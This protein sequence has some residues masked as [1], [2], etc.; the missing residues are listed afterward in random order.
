MRELLQAIHHQ[1]LVVVFRED[2]ALSIIHLRMMILILKVE[3]Y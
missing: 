2:D 3:H 1:D